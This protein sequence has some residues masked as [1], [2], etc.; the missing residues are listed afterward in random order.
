MIKNVI[1]NEFLNHIFYFGWSKQIL[2][3]NYL[4]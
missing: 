2:N 3:I 1:K 4:I